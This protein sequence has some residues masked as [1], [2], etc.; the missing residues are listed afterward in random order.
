ME[1]PSGPTEAVLGKRKSG[2]SDEGNNSAQWDSTSSSFSAFHNA[3]QGY[4]SPTVDN[5]KRSKQQVRTWIRTHH[6]SLVL[7]NVVVGC[8]MSVSVQGAFGNEGQNVQQHFWV[9]DHC[10]QQQAS[11]G[12]CQYFI[13]LHCK[14]L[15]LA[16]DVR[17]AV[18]VARSA[19]PLARSRRSP[20]LCYV[21]HSILGIRPAYLR[22]DLSLQ[23]PATNL[24]VGST[25]T[26]TDSTHLL[27]FYRHPTAACGQ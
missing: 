19:P 5:F 25:P 26:G 9:W 17:H 15:S 14:R 12:T 20:I 7:Y 23:D 11:P 10:M 16:S 6:L 13:P 2:H 24:Q 8:L 27:T 18:L 21:R 3:T 1:Q 4:G 22:R